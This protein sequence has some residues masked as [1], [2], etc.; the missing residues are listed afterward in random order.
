MSISQEKNVPEDFMIWEWFDKKV[1][2]AYDSATNQILEQACTE[3]QDTLILDHGFFSS[4]PYT[5]DFK[6]KQQTNDRT[7]FVRELRRSPAKATTNVAAWVCLVKKKWEPYDQETSQILEA[8]YCAGSPKVILQHGF[9]AENGPYIVDF[10][11]MKQMNKQTG[12]VREIRRTVNPKKENMGVTASPNSIPKPDKRNSLMPRG[13]PIPQVSPEKLKPCYGTIMITLKAGRDI[14]E[15]STLGIDPYVVI[16]TDFNPTVHKSEWRFK[17]THPVWNQQFSI[18]VSRYDME[19]NVLFT[20]Y[21]HNHLKKNNYLGRLDIPLYDIVTTRDELSGWMALTYEARKKSKKQL[22]GHL[23]VT[24]KFVAKPQP[25]PTQIALTD[26]LQTG[27][28]QTHQ[29]M[30]RNASIRSPQGPNIGTSTARRFT[31]GIRASKGIDSGVPPAG[32]EGKEVWNPPKEIVK[33]ADPN[34]VEGILDKY[35]LGDVLGEGGFAVVKKATALSNQEK[36]AIKI[37][38]K[39]IQADAEAINLITREIQILHLVEH[40]SCVSFRESRE[41]ADTIYIVMEFVGGGDLLDAILDAGGFDEKRSAKAINDILHGL[42]YLHNTGI[43][44]RDMKPE[45]VLFHPETNVWKIA[46]FGCATLFTDQ[47]P[48]MHDFE[49][50]IQYM[51]PEILIG[52]KYTKSI[53]IWATGVITYVSL[54]ACFPWEGRTDAEVQESIMSYKI[55]FYSPEFDN[56]SP[57]AIGFILRLLEMHVEKRITLETALNHVWIKNNAK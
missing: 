22:P 45:N 39:T 25:P 9:Y 43:C 32:K 56:V 38:A 42:D 33:F 55:K 11:E 47:N 15:V 2:V 37:I 18:P 27:D 51:A 12:F 6:K 3:G 49:G 54:S 44:H 24:V 5:V 16:S 46:D 21:N 28:M 7:K 35:A 14:A 53:D 26:I 48:Y 10:V 20:L 41:T 34:V 36:V 4:G 29:L 52:E 1:W 40:G 17:T 50:T 23:E 30:A 19:G 13:S 8:E 57:D 31:M